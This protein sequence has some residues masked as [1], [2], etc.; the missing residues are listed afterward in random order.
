MK[1]HKDSVQNI[2]EYLSKLPEKERVVLEELR[3][4]IKEAAPDAQ[5]VISY[6]MPAFNYKGMLV[7]FAAFTRHCSLFG[8]NSTLTEDMKEELK[9]YKTSKGTIQ[10]TVDKPLPKEIVK[11]IV[12]LRVI[13]NEMK[14]EKTASK[15]ALKK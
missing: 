1:N 2:D 5:E 10:F 8:G 11:K 13:Q 7:Y 3:Q 4:T 14:N 12:S 15:K 9:D 6:Q